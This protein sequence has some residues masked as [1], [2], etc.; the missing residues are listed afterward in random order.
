MRIQLKPKDL[1]N[2]Y[3]E[4]WDDNTFHPLGCVKA[5]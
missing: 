1:P 4:A 5:R 2:I 3:I